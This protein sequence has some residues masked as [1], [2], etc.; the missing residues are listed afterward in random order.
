MAIPTFSEWLSEADEDSLMQDLTSIGFE[1]YKGWI[2][3]TESIFYKSIQTGIYAVVAKTVH[4]ASAFILQNM[5]VLDD[6]N[7]LADPGQGDTFED[8]LEKVA[9]DLM[10]H[11]RLVRVYEGLIPI[12]KE[13]YCLEVDWTNPLMTMK[14]LRTIFNNVDTVLN[15][16]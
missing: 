9:D 11:F 4:D 5:G 2:V 16:S 12:K 3:C 1:G 13:E 14:D 8:C 7:D 15:K 10:R 6:A